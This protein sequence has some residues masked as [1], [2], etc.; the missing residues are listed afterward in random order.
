MDNIMKGTQPQP[1]TQPQSFPLTGVQEGFCANRGAI[2]SIG[3]LA[4][5]VSFNCPIIGLMPV[6]LTGL[7][8][9]S[10]YVA[11][12]KTLLFGLGWA[13]IWALFAVVVVLVASY[14]VARPAF[15]H[16]SR[17]VAIHSYWKTAGLMGLT[18]GLS[19]ILWWQLIL[20]LVFI[21]GVPMGR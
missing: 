16:Y 17:E 13:P 2:A 8:F 12:D 4:G 1:Q 21:L 3:F 18:A 10:A 7:G 5:W 6:V 19:F 11:L 9:G 14:F 20:P 15:T